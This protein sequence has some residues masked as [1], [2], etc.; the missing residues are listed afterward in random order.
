MIKLTR[1]DGEPF[2]LNAELIRYVSEQN[3]MVFLPTPH[4]VYA[5]NKEVVFTPGRSAFV[6]LREIEVTDHHWSMRGDRPYP[7]ERT[8][9]RRIGRPREESPAR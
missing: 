7:A 6:Y 3:Y 2:V 4:N 9:P 8:R 5:V 1:L